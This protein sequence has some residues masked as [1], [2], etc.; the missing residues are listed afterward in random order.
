MAQQ[1]HEVIWSLTNAYI[2]SRLLHIVA[3]MGVADDVGD[4]AVSARELAAKHGVDADALDRILRLLAAHGIF[5]VEGDGFRH[6]PASELLRSDHPMS[7][8]AFPR[9][10]GLPV[11][12]KSFDN[13][14]HSLET[15]SPAVETVE[16]RGVW[17]YFQD[18]PVEAQIFNESMTAK[19]AADIPTILAAYDFSRFGTIA[20]IG[21]GRG[22]LLRAVLDSAPGA[23]G[24]LFDLPGVI[25][26]VDVA[27]ERLKKQPGDF[28]ADPLPRADAYVLMEVIHDW[29][30]EQCVAI[31]KAIRAAAPDDATV[32]IIENVLPDDELDP[33]GQTLDAIML[34]VAGGRERT[35]SQLNALLNSAGF[36]QGAVIETAGPLR[37]V[38]ASAA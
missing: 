33:R 6:T 18:H 22:H 36:S 4:G 32:L 13:L 28:F 16:P 30:D 10:M 24:V 34:A 37:I 5:A 25:A 27:H 17:A 14:Q 15:G 9:M 11:F 1:P 19:A 2:P 26:S 35:P 29:H 21:G 12:T 38:E 23:H 8:R 7:M 3:E 31:L 20:D